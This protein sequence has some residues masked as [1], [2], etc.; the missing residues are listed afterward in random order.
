MTH[1]ELAAELKLTR[2]FISITRT[3]V[4]KDPGELS[5]EDFPVK[6][7]CTLRA[8]KNVFDGRRLVFTEKRCSCSGATGGFG[9][10]DGIPDMPGGLEYFLTTGAGE[11]FPPGERLKASPETGREML[12]LEPPNVLAPYNAIECKPYE[13]GDNPDLVTMLITADQLAAFVN[14]YTFRTGAYDNVIMPMSSGCATIFRIPFAELQS[15]KPRAVIGNADITSR[16][17]FDADK[18]FL[19]VTGARFLEMLADAGDSFIFTPYF[20]GV[21][22]RL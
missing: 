18:V 11:G 13:T 10:V 12:E 17:F 22:K 15:K 21:K 4:P 16:F 14:L 2:P 6:S 8:L 20:T 19:T 7:G 9:F 1:S 3:T 5:P